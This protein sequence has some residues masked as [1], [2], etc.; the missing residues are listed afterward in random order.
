MRHRTL[1]ALAALVLPLLGSALLAPAAR[2]E[3]Q[4]ESRFWIDGRAT[5]GPY[6]CEVARVN[7]V[8]QL[9]KDLVEATITVPVA[10]F[11]CGMSR[12]NRDFYN[13]LRGDS[14]PSIRFELDH[15]GVLDA[16][17][18]VGAWVPV[19]AVGMLHLAGVTQRVAVRAEGQQLRDGRVRIR[20]QHPLLMSD[21]GI[22]PPSGLLGLVRASDRV[23]AR[24]DITASPR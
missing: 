10:G 8:A 7:G 1:I 3:V 24:F 11:D 16:S 5:T 20:G 19:V 17:S 9:E 6:S 22:E 21:F 4:T 23:V 2:Y 15:A 12:M 13:A 14:H 18:E